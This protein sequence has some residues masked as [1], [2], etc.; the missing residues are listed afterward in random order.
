MK[1][2]REDMQGGGREG[3]REGEWKDVVS[4]EHAFAHAIH[5]S[6]HIFH[7]ETLYLS[8]VT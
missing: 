3:G 1:K 7:R 6:L 2:T 5:E 4:L 8:L